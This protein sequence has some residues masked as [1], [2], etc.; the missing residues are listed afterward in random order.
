[1]GV[2]LRW[3]FRQ[4]HCLR[5]SPNGKIKKMKIRVARTDDFPKIKRL[6]KMYPEKLLQTHLPKVGQFFVAIEDEDIIG[7]GCERLVTK[8]PQGTCSLRFLAG[9]RN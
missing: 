5:R 7:C 1:M 9:K 8:K 4:D 6:I 2:F 3:S